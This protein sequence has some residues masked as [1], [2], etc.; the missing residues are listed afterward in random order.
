LRLNVVSSIYA[1]AFYEG[2][3]YTPDG[4]P[5][6]VGPVVGDLAL[7]KGGGARSTSR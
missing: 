3:G 4:P 6:C 2:N 1:K 7:S 5:R